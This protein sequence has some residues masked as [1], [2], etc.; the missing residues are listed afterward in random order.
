MRKR[1]GEIAVDKSKKLAY[2]AQ[3]AWIMNAT[4]R[5]NIIFGNEFDSQW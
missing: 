2:V 5:E 1:G 3:Q 4:V